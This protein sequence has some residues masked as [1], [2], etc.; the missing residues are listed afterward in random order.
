MTDFDLANLNHDIDQQARDIICDVIL[1]WARLDS[2][3]SQLTL[4]AFGLALDGGTIL[5]GS[6]DTKTKLDRLKKLYDHFGMEEAAQSIANLRQSH[7][8]FVDVR[9]TIAHHTCAGCWKS[10]PNMIVFAPVRVPHKQLNMVELSHVPVKAMARAARFAT[11][12]GNQLLEVNDKLSARTATPPLEP[13]A[14]LPPSP[15]N[16]Q[17]SGEQEQS[18]QRKA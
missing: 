18:P 3:V 6:M 15:P 9:N 2:L 10:D 5:L 4:L 17:T 7:K 16:P 11:E 13:P 1:S 12:V 8:D 14:F